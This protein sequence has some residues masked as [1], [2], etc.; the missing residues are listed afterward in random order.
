MTVIGIAPD[1][2]RFALTDTAKPEM[3]VPY[4]QNPYP[5]FLTMQFVVRSRRSVAS[6][7]PSIRDAVAGV[8]R[9][10]PV[11][12]VRTIADLIGETSASARFATMLMSGFGAAALLLAMLGVY[13]LVAFTVQQRRQEFGVRR[14]LGAAP[15]EVLRLVVREGLQLAA[16]GIVVGLVIALGAGF[17]LRHLLYEV[18]AYDPFTLGGTVL[19]L[20]LAT[21]AACIGPAWRASRVEARTALEEL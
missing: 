17:A 12:H 8:D 16:G 3:I 18:A 9:S 1:M 4:T 11:S 15:R 6:L 2:K 21:I 5:S 13:G 19:V 7:L 20:A 14:A 10:V